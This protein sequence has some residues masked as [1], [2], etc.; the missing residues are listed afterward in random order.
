MDTAFMG[1]TSSRVSRT[2]GDYQPER[3][4][5]QTFSCRPT[6]CSGHTFQRER[7]FVVEPPQPLIG[8]VR[9]LRPVF[10]ADQMQQAEHDVGV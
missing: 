7:Q 9:Q 5:A 4:P 1:L 6:V 3:R 8:Q 2:S 10:D